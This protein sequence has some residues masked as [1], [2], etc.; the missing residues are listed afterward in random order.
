MLGQDLARQHS[1]EKRHPETSI[2]LIERVAAGG[3]AP[4]I[5]VGGGEFTLVDDLL[6]YRY[7]NLTGQPARVALERYRDL[8]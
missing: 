5:D 4:M 3:S 8:P 7:S 1:P 6:H 2:E